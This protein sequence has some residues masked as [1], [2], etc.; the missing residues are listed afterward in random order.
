MFNFS[1]FRLHKFF[2][3]GDSISLF[4]VWKQCFGTYA[5]QIYYFKCIQ[6]KQMKGFQWH[7]MLSDYIFSYLNVNFHPFYHVLDACI[8]NC[9][10]K[11]RSL[12]YFLFFWERYLNGF[13]RAKCTGNTVYQRYWLLNK[14]IQKMKKKIAFAVEKY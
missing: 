10:I 3:G 11:F 2:D 14:T 4:S 8:V 1:L 13:F 12:D 5:L 7:W 9:R 6:R